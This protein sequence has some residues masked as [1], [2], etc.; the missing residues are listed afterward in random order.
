MT[1]G[2]SLRKSIEQGSLTED[3][4]DF[5]AGMMGLL[6]EIGATFADPESSKANQEAARRVAA[7]AA[8]LQEW[9]DRRMQGRKVRKEALDDQEE[10]DDQEEGDDAEEGADD[11]DNPTSVSLEKSV[12]RRLKGLVS[13]RAFWESI[14]YR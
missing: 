4:D 10:A 9:I 2:E 5:I 1:L 11:D 12:R 6:Q 8:V 7:K 13:E 3:D 14:G